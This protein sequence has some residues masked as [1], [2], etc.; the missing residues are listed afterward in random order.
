MQILEVYDAGSGIAAYGLL[1]E[2]FIW[3]I[4]YPAA[5]QRDAATIER[6]Y[7]AVEVLLASP[8]VNLQDAVAIRVTPYMTARP[9]REFTE[10]SAGEALAS[11]VAD[12]QVDPNFDPEY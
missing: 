1:S 7:E 4:F 11:S 6:C 3:G 5:K 9:W 10:Q 8:D 12:V 2:V